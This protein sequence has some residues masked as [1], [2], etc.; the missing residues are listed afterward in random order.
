VQ[1]RSSFPNK[2]ATALIALGIVLG[3]GGLASDEGNQAGAQETT[4]SERTTPAAVP[5]APKPNAEAWV[6]TDADSGLYLAGENPDEQLPIGSTTKIMTALE[7]LKEGVDPNEEVTVP[8]EAEAYVGDV[9]SNVG[10]IADER[11]S[12]RDLLEAAL[13]PS[14]TDAAYTLAQEFGSGS[15]D[16]FVDKMNK[17]ASSMGLQNTHFDTPAGLDSPGNYSSARDLA[18]IAQ[19]ALKYP[20][21]AQIVATKDATI[22]TQNRQIEIHNTNQ[23]LTTYPK[24]TGVKTGT[25]PEAGANLVASAADGNASYISVVLDEGEDPERFQDSRSILDYAF[26]NYEHRTLISQDE[27]YGEEPL[28]YRRGESVKLAAEKDVA[29]AVTPSSQVERRVTTE[30]LPSEAEAGQELGEVEVSVDGQNAGSSPLVAQEG[31]GEASL[32]DKVWYYSLGWVWE[33]VSQL[34]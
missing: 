11:L 31:Y 3:L 4:S 18:T 30:E 22:S 28:P 14:G 25:T 19:A 26:N 13:I 9:Y 29:A 34:L 16:N 2:A 1:A 7:I 12:V 23:L 8:T 17:Q 10:L 33:K 27:V 21:F 6:L 5:S 15:V 32:W 24:A 20:L